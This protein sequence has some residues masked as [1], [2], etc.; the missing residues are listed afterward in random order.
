[1]ARMLTPRRFLVT[2][3]LRFAR[4]CGT[5]EGGEISY[6]RRGEC[7]LYQFCRRKHGSG[8]G[9]RRLLDGK[10]R[11]LR[12]SESGTSVW[13]GDT[14]NLTNQKEC[15]KDLA[16]QNQQS[17][18]LERNHLNAFD[19]QYFGN[20]G[21]G[22]RGCDKVTVEASIC[23]ESRTHGTQTPQMDESD[24]SAIDDQYFQ[25]VK[26][27]SGAPAHSTTSSHDKKSKKTARPGRTLRGHFMFG[28]I[29]PKYF[30]DINSSFV[31][32]EAS[33]DRS[34]DNNVN[35]FD[36]QYFGDAN[37]TAH[38]VQKAPVTFIDTD[39]SE[40]KIFSQFLS[41]QKTSGRRDPSLSS[42]SKTKEESSKV[43][44][45]HDMPM[46]YQ[47]ISGEEFKDHR[48]VH[49]V[50]EPTV[51]KVFL[52]SLP[53]ELRGKL[54]AQQQWEEA[55][56]ELRIGHHNVEDLEE[57][58]VS[59]FKNVKKKRKKVVKPLWGRE[60]KVFGTEDITVPVSRAT[61]SGCGAQLHC[62][63]MSRPG[64]V[65][66]EKFKE[67][68]LAKNIS[69]AICQRCWYLI[70][71][72]TALN[73]N[74]SGDTYSDITRTIYKNHKALV[75]LLVDLLD[76]PC[77]IIKDLKTQVGP[78]R[79]IVIIGN[80]FDVLPK[81]EPKYAN[82]IKEQL[83][84]ACVEMGVCDA[85]KVKYVGL[86]SAKT[87]YGVEEL[88]T[89]LISLRPSK[90]DIYLLGTAN[91]GKSTLFNRF[92]ESDLC[93]GKA[94]RHIGRATI[95]RWPG[96]TINLLRFPLLNPTQEKL[97]LRGRRLHEE[98]EARQ[99]EKKLRRMETQRISRRMEKDEIEFPHNAYL[100]G[101]VE[102]T[103]ESKS[104]EANEAA[105]PEDGDPF[106]LALKT[107]SL[108]R[109]RTKRSVDR[110][111]SSTP[112]LS[113]YTPEELSRT[114]WFFDTPGVIYKDQVLT[115]LTV[116]ELKSVV[117]QK[118][119]LPRSFVLRPG[120]SFFLGGLGRLD[121]LEG[122]QSS[123]F[124]VFSHKA[125]PIKVM[126]TDK[127]DSVYA[128]KAGEKYFV[129]PEGGKER[130]Q[131]F[132]PLQSREF[133]LTGIGQH[134]SVADILFSS[135]GWVAVTAN[136]DMDVLLRAFTPGGRGC[137]MRSPSL[138]PYAFS[139]RG[140]RRS[141][142]SPFYDISKHKLLFHWR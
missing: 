33:P 65:P 58:V 83:V 18:D 89:K 110:S 71:S 129:V 36:R 63:D 53:P 81:D 6:Q 29:N 16:N 77:S 118:S 55:K 97:A 106:S 27:R 66:S 124:T 64:F 45:A 11:H 127:A 119:I 130:M 28:D 43:L 112:V 20:L 103:F 140:A 135:V 74:I 94:S 9:R 42:L 113:L 34:S 26:S 123:Y 67:L 114:Q 4:I 12:S 102:R 17:K 37:E 14:E 15:S 92:L 60:R 96:T 23:H 107:P 21:D 126:D 40:E 142:K 108:E 54:K 22:D 19:A 72:H 87:G 105:L 132:P 104:M 1:M 5:A 90:G 61:C 133:S 3:F 117:P 79:P 78:W 41:Q 32:E 59:A 56:E 115:L 57:S 76:F 99:K 88:I 7:I 80:K 10:D 73:V 125:L 82:R 120:Q 35:E 136:K 13:R 30:D 46:D 69:S 95:S 2:H 84:A 141:K 25:D 101:S 86:I 51:D 121:Y 138:I 137:L 52:D 85:D 139:L 39:Q 38:G 8:R 109:D 44:P 100:T 75:V 62:Q 48:E 116:G 31:Y 47:Q 68:N 134:K 50:T 111:S 49:I 98:R 91:V 128:E 122:K 24:L 70:H 93:Q 131:N